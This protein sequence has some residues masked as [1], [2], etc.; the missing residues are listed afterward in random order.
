MQN[1]TSNTRIIPIFGNPIK[2]SLSPIMQNAWLIENKLDFIYLAFEIKTKDLGQAVQSIKILNMVGANITVPHKNDVIKYLDSV[3]KSAKIIGSV[4]TIVNKKGKLIGYNTDGNGLI[5][6]LN[7]KKIEL[8][9]KI[10]LVVGAGGASKAVLFALNKLKV[11][12]IYLT[13]RTYT[14]AKNISKLYRNI[15]PIEIN[16]ISGDLLQQVD[17]IINSSTCGMNLND[18]LPFEIKKYKNNI[19]LYDLIYNKLTPFKKFAVKHNLKYFSGEGM[20]IHQGSIAFEMWTNIK[21]NTKKTLT[22]L[23]NFMR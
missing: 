20:L 10:V 19:I 17:C 15:N 18:K 16:K 13:S 9:N 1:I 4:N 21:P 11:K 8:K 7:S 5:S 23:K 2:H 3:D 12:K 14:T 22:L 6:D